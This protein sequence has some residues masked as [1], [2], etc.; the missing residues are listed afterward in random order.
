MSLAKHAVRQ[1]SWSGYISW[2]L[3]EE[4]RHLARQDL[5][6]G[7]KIDENIKWKSI[8]IH[9]QKDISS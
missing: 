3:T 2:I 1:I 9:A 8:Q 4:T 7:E 6:T 5:H